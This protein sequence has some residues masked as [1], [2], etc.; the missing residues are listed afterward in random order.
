M[1]INEDYRDSV[2]MRQKRY[3][4][5]QLNTINAPNVNQIV[6]I[7]DRVGGKYEEQANIILANAVR[8]KDPGQMLKAKE[9]I[10]NLQKLAPA[11]FKG[12]I[13]ATADS[14]DGYYD[15]AQANEL[16]GESLDRITAKFDALPQYEKTKGG[17]EI[18]EGLTNKIL[19]E[20]KHVEK[21]NINRAIAKRAEMK[22]MMTSLQLLGEWDADPST[23]DV[24][25][26]PKEFDDEI[27]RSLY[28]SAHKTQALYDIGDYGTATSELI[29]L[30]GKDLTLDKALWRYE[31]Q[32]A[33]IERK[34]QV[35]LA[36]GKVKTA[37][38]LKKIQNAGKLDAL[39]EI[40]RGFDSTY[41]LYGQH[42]VPKEVAEASGTTDPAS[43]ALWN[44]QQGPNF[45]QRQDANGVL[46]APSLTPKDLNIFLNGGDPFSEQFKDTQADYKLPGYVT[47]DLS[48]ISE[49]KAIDEQIGQLRES[50]G[51]IKQHLSQ[52]QEHLSIEDKDTGNSLAVAI[53]SLGDT[54]LG[55][56]DT[57]LPYTN[58]RSAIG[59]IDKSIIGIINKRNSSVWP[60]TIFWGRQ[61]GWQTPESI[62]SDFDLMTRDPLEDADKTDMDDI[63]AANLDKLSK[64]KRYANT[65][66]ELMAARDELYQLVLDDL[67]NQ[68][69]SG[70][71]EV[72][73]LGDLDPDKEY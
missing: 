32:L 21:S 9:D 16:F 49:Q 45:Q 63:I 73:D 38:K 42:G 48:L 68:K 7:I 8:S 20:N 34:I 67:V 5:D 56:G 44:A 13:G 22:E 33:E 55:S 35:K 43:A 14:L 25:D 50:L 3:I 61:V 66:A 62:V 18:V 40:K 39:G 53:A 6:G 1:A 19:S 4:M 2:F 72:E 58:A 30:R 12:V 36:A 52:A 46:Y 28:E 70:G 47:A 51:S 59:A 31:N 29:K 60:D 69:L 27:Q 37:A 57:A 41:K 23:P 15:M 11:P 24:M 71:K 10:L 54:M 26:M 65:V 17:P 64:D